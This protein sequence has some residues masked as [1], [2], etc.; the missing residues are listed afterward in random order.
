MYSIY[1]PAQ[2]LAIPQTNLL[3]LPAYTLVASHISSSIAIANPS[4]MEVLLKPLQLVYIFSLSWTPTVLCICLGRRR[5]NHHNWLHFLS[6]YKLFLSPSLLHSES[7]ALWL[8]GRTCIYLLRL[9]RQRQ[10]LILF[11]ML[12]GGNNTTRMRPS[13]FAWILHWWL[14]EWV[15]P[16]TL[17]LSW[18]TPHLCQVPLQQSLQW[19]LLG[20]FGFLYVRK[21]HSSSPIKPPMVLSHLQKSFKAWHEK[22]YQKSPKGTTP[23]LIHS[24]MQHPHP[25]LC[26]FTLWHM[27]HAQLIFDD[28]M[29]YK[30]I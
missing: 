5:I 17:L 7:F 23:C 25:T 2:P 30:W 16:L 11:C 28:W 1:S 29:V 9:W 18:F 3:A 24:C 21:T 12:H 10:T 20:W 6:S 15:L 27:V 22:V 14:A 8:S 19:F 4:P 13:S 26:Q